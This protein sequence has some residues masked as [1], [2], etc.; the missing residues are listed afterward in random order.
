MRFA[1]LSCAPQ[2]FALLRSAPLSCAKLRLAWRRFAP[3]RCGA[4]VRPVKVRHAQVCPAEDR[5]AEHR[6]AEI[7]V[8]ELRS[9]EIRDYS[10]VCLSPAIPNPCTFLK[11]C[12]MFTVRHGASLSLALIIRC[13]PA[14]AKAANEL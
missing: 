3:L 5:L 12:E 9:A 2:R 7:R 10:G 6:V 8:A 11:F 13:G 4:E 14:A 1:P